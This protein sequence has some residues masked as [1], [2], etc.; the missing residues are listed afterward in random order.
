MSVVR[1]KPSNK[2]R[3]KKF[4]KGE[5]A[6]NRQPPGNQSPALSW[7]FPVW[8]LLRKRLPVSADESPKSIKNYQNRKIFL[9][10]INLRQR[11]C[12][13]VADKAVNNKSL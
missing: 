2:R 11:R 5:M 10:E 12:Y 9:Q 3:D 7:L 4:E 1:F 6:E 8:V 13:V